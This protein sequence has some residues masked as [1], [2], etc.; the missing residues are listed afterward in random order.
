MSLREE[1]REI[2]PS[3]CLLASSHYRNYFNRSVL[4][5][6][7][8]GGGG[9]GRRRP[10][11]RAKVARCT[12][13]GFLKCTTSEQSNLNIKPVNRETNTAVLCNKEQGGAESFQAAAVC[14]SCPVFRKPER[15]VNS[16]GL[17]DKSVRVDC[18][19]AGW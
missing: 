15:T 19:S 10:R 12:G 14:Q 8:R 7:D 1:E 16:A 6:G 5:R 18:L 3:R 17:R 9:G 11:A 13:H 4:Q 2:H